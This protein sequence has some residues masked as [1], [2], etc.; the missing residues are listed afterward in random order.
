M[1]KFPISLFLLAMV[2][3]AVVYVSASAQ[4]QIA[5]PSQY[6][7]Y[8]GAW[9]DIDYPAGWKATPFG[10]SISSTTGSDS[11][12]F[13]SPDRSAEFYVFSPQWNG[14]PAE[15]KLNPRREVLVSS[16]MERASRGKMRDGGYI[17]NNIAHW[18]TARARDNSYERSWTDVEDKGLNVRYIFGIKY[19]NQATYQ[20]Y[21]MQYAHFRKSLIQFGD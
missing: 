13:T 18:Y 7:K 9:F 2:L 4:P 20:K 19:R 1:A 11:A 12:R 14:D 6:T 5:H 21:R 8:T 17:S 10:R 16:R 15:I 3:L